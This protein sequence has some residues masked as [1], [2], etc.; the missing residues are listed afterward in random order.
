M[1]P[2]GTS[3][4]TTL[5]HKHAFC[6]YNSRIELRLALI[7]LSNKPPMS[8]SSYLISLCELV[9]ETRRAATSF[10]VCSWLACLGKTGRQCN[11]QRGKLFGPLGVSSPRVKD[12]YLIVGK[13]Y[14]SR[15]AW[16]DFCR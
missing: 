13:V 1:L 12:V 10:A 6:W 2:L 15:Q 11:E 9:G 4:L 3:N 8:C 16:T 7:C 14:S 5:T